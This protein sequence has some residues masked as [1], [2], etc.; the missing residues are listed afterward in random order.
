YSIE[1]HGKAI[2]VVANNI[3]KIKKSEY[4]EQYRKIKELIGVH[5]IIPYSAKKKIGVDDLLK[6]ILY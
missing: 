1:D 2:S 3:D 4:K 6:E 5:K